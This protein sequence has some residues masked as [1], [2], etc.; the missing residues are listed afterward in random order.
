MAW[1]SADA[2]SFEHAYRLFRDPKFAWALTHT[3]AGSPLRLPLPKSKSNARRPSGRRL[4]RPQHAGRWLRDRHPPRRAGRP[5][6]AL[7]MMYGRRAGHTQDDLLDI[8]LQGF[9]GSSPFHMAIRAT[10]LLGVLLDPATTSRGR[11]HSRR[12]TGPGGALRRGRAGPVFE[13]R[14]QAFRRSR[15]QGKLEL[16]RT[17]RGASWPGRRRA[18]S[19]FTA[20]LL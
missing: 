1:H 7:W 18:P 2:A 10:G 4:E 3:P 14:A 11:S 13:A 15:R 5:E 9:Q 16:P 20:R 19:D 8:G 12:M 6:A 17:V